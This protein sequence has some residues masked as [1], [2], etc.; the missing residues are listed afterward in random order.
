[1]KICTICSNEHE[2]KSVFCSEKCQRTACSK[3]YSRRH[4]L[5]NKE[6]EKARAHAYRQAHPEQVRMRKMQQYHECKDKLS[7]DRKLRRSHD[8]NYKMRST[9]R[10]RLNCAIKNG[11][12]AGSAVKDLG[13]TIADLKTYLESKFLLG[14]SWDNWSKDGWHIDHIEPLSK[15]DLTNPEE[16]KKACHYT[17]LQPL[18]AKDN[19]S[20]SNKILS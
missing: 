14:M 6:K 13:C 4:Y 1:M 9:L 19:I 12:K 8:L 18:W 15:F 16:F 11:Q 2:R 7:N 20:K 3:E 10:A 17:N 5:K